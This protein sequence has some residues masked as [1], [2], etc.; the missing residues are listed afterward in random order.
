MP[1]CVLCSACVCVCVCVVYVCV[2]A[3][4]RVIVCVCLRMCLCSRFALVCRAWSR[5]SD[6]TLADM[7]GLSP[8][9]ATLGPA[10]GVTHHFGYNPSNL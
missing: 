9:S 6:S 7:L 1:L 4:V 10:P 5:T 8:V 2:R 3:C